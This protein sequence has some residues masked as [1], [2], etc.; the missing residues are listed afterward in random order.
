MTKRADSDYYD[1]LPQTRTQMAVSS[2]LTVF[3][4]ASATT[5]IA[6]GVSLGF[7]VLFV[8]GLVIPWVASILN[9]LAVILV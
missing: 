7:A 3:L 9:R 5:V 2:M 1:A 8:D 6:F 4:C